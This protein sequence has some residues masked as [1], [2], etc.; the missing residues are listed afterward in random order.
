MGVLAF[1]VSV[2]FWQRIRLGTDLIAQ[3]QPELFKGAHGDAWRPPCLG[4]PGCKP[5]DRTGEGRGSGA[6]SFPLK[7][8]KPPLLCFLKRRCSKQFAVCQPYNSV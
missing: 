7:T 4:P 1:V 8:P 3:V 2:C 6:I 5:F